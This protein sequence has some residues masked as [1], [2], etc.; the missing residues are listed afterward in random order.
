MTVMLSV[1]LLQQTMCYRTPLREPTDLLA[2]PPPASRKPFRLIFTDRL[3]SNKQEPEGLP[4]QP[5]GLIS[6]FQVRCIC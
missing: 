6:V 5:A 2:V 1:S 3:P 4:S